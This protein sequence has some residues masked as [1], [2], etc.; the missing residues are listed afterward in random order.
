MKTLVRFASPSL[1]SLQSRLSIENSP[2]SRTL[3]S[4]SARVLFACMLSQITLSGKA[5]RADIT[6]KAFDANEAVEMSLQVASSGEGL[7]AVMTLEPFLLLQR[8]CGEGQRS[9]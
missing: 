7:R 4:S 1:V 3:Q 6:G 5:L 8:H 9:P 2:T